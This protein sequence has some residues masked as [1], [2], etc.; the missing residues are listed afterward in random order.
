[1]D[2]KELSQKYKPGH[3][4]G[5]WGGLMSL[6]GTYRYLFIAVYLEKVAELCV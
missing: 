4:I 5:I 2:T 1:M 3:R 6:K